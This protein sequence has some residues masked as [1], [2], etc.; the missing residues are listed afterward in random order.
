MKILAI[1]LAEVGRFTAPVA[2]EGLSGGL[3]VLAGPNEL[4]KSTILGALD[5]VLN[6]RHSAGTEALR[7]LQPYGG[8]AP[9]VEIDF[10]M[11]GRRYRLRKSFIKRK[12]AELRDLDGGAS[13]RNDDAE[14]R[15]E[16]LLARPR[17]VGALGLVWVPQGASTAKL[18]VKDDALVPLQTFVMDCVEASADGGALQRLRRRVRLAIEALETAKNATPRGAYKDAIQLERTV[19]A[20][21]DAAKARLA[22]A[23]A[24]LDRLDAVS[25][26]IAE[27]TGPVAAAL[28]QD[29]VAE[30]N[31]ALA[32]ARHAHEEAQRAAL[33]ELASRDAAAL[34]ANRFEALRTKLK[35][36]ADLAHSADAT[37]GEIV[38]QLPRV[39][40][41]RASA[42]AAGNACKALGEKLAALAE[43]VSGAKAAELARR[44]AQAAELSAR[45]AE[46]DAQLAACGATRER[47]EAAR[48]ADATMIAARARLDAA[49][50]RVR[51][52]Y[53]PGVDER[54]ALGGVALAGGA[55]IVAREAIAIE[56]AG[57]GRILVTPP[58]AEPGLLAEL[59]AAESQRD[60]QLAAAGASTVREVEAAVDVR[61]ELE[62]ER[63][64]VAAELRVIAPKVVSQAGAHEDAP[65]AKDHCPS[66]P[67]VAIEADYEGVARD[68]RQHEAALAHA[69]R[70]LSELLRQ[71][72]AARATLHQQEQAHAALDEELAPLSTCDAR[73]VELQDEAHALLQRHGEHARA[74]A[75]WR[76][77]A[78]DQARLT[79]LERAATNARS[80]QDAARSQAQRLSEEARQIEG[81]LSRDQEEDI[82]SVVR[83]LTDRHAAA[84]ARRDDFAAEVAALR[85]LDREFSAAEDGE[86][87][88]LLSPVLERIAPHLRRL[89]PDATIGLERSYAA[90]DVTRNG[91]SE[92]ID[93]LSMGTR[94]Q[95]AILA[96]LGFAR[97][98]AD[99]GASVPLVLDDALVFADDR[100]IASM[101]ECLAEA[102]RH[103]QVIV[104]TCR[105]SAFGALPGN[106]LSLA[107]WRQSAWDTSHSAVAVT[108]V[109]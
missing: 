22:A 103:H 48:R 80:A 81:A 37:R 66:R 35:R 36:R 13:A 65:P 63:H 64:R 2:L 67:L 75:A 56:I 33:Q 71:D 109:T 4:G 91:V 20:E 107:P 43:E 86:M 15:L 106:R 85:L 99:R 32:D 41:A 9:T 45:L 38:R 26:D 17:S 29:Q 93:R 51:I 59:A 16:E 8:G 46:I 3:D 102:A 58:A 5:A 1:R 47:L 72:A 98:L 19:A 83:S 42:E 95:V 6:Q 74:L 77:V 52:E 108:T 94:E 92:P 53:E 104:L 82:E 14:R 62:T 78:P 30:T 23:R 101:F 68:L 96:R 60:R 50:T 70:A 7:R 90:R 97:L 87:G 88:R 31:K 44:R 57:I 39:D 12:A 27:L 18:E 24:R 49:A 28:R 21:L 54:I 69:E 55:E 40:A 25:A 79:A 61:V 34:A 73:L 76:A 11:Q 89:F 105:E 84:Q 10:E 100:R